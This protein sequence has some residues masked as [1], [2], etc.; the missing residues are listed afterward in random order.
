[1]KD[2]EK[3]VALIRLRDM[4]YFGVEPTV[5][6]CGLPPELIQE[7]AKDELVLLRDRKFGDNLDRFVIHEI[8]PAG[9]DF[10]AQ[11]RARREQLRS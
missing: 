9:H 3:F 6:Q 11:L 5:R 4:I 7:L 1:M 8:L 10:I 2:N